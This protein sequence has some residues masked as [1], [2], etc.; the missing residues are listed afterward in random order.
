MPA[1]L[2]VG[3]YLLAASAQQYRTAFRTVSIV[4]PAGAFPVVTDLTS[5][6]LNAGD[7]VA[8]TLHV[9]NIGNAMAR[10]ISIQLASSNPL[11]TFS[12]T[13][14][15][16][17]S[18]EAGASAD[19]SSAVIAI[20]NGNTPD[21]T[22]TDLSTS[23][24][25]SGCTLAGTSS[26][27]LWLYAPVLS[28]TFSN[29]FP[30]LL[31][32]NSGAITVT[33]HNS[34]HAPASANTLSFSSPTTLLSVLHSSF[35]APLTANATA[36][37][38]VTLQSDARSPRNIIVPVACRYASLSDTLPVFIGELDIETFEGGTTHCTGWNT[39]VTYPWATSTEQP[40]EGSYCLRSAQ[41]LDHKKQS[42]ISFNTSFASADSVSFYYRVSSENNYDK[43]FFLIDSVEMLDASGEM[44]WTRAAFFLSAGSHVL[45]FRYKK[46]YSISDGSDCAWIDNVV[47]PHQSH[48][49]SF[50]HRD[51]CLDS[52]PSTQT[53]VAANGDVTIIDYTAHPSYEDTLRVSTQATSYEWYGTVYYTSGTYRQVFTTS[54]GCDS[55]VI[56]VLTFGTT[57]DIPGIAD[58]SSA[59]T[60][61]PNP[62]TGGLH[63]GLPVDEVTVYDLTGRIVA[64]L[65]Q[66]VTLDL[67]ALASGLYT[68]RLTSSGTT[69]VQRV[70]KQ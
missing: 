32:G 8:L 10:N 5:D 62:T 38:P 22:P 33:L 57:Q 44:P 24:S 34:G 56:L 2:S 46:D 59:L 55:V 20:V 19:L 61:Y 35:S 52:T 15:F 6:P 36:S 68:L 28:L 31:P 70:V 51:T 47:F 23:T 13:T 45:T 63:L 26:F 50:I 30:D 14:V 7:T 9:E 60:V 54:Q 43:F 27:R 29:T 16:L 3:S 37:I 39:A 25:W 12:T 4:Q 11:L 42:D 1:D 69:A 40:F 66:T 64:Q 58:V 21:N 53:S 65:R 17:D 41:N 18:L 48:P 49:V 67:S